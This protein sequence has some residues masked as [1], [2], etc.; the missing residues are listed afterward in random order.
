MKKPDHP[1][2]FLLKLEWILLAISCFLE[3]LP[4]PLT[5]EMQQFSLLPFLFIGVFG[6][7]GLFLPTK[8]NFRK[9]LY[10]IVEFALIGSAS[11]LIHGFHPFPFL[12]LLLMIRSCL[13]FELPGRL[14]VAAIVLVAFLVNFGIQVSQFDLP[15]QLESARFSRSGAEALN[16]TL[17][18][19]L[20]FGLVL[21][22]VLLLVNAL[23]S[24]RLSRQKLSDANLRLREY[25]RRIEDQ[26]A[27]QERN[28]IA[29]DIHDSLGHSLT[30]LNIQMEAVIELW[31]RDPQKARGFL[32]DAKHSGTTALQAVR[33]SV[34][35]LR[36]DPL[37]GH[38]LSS[39]LDSLA[40]E[41]EQTVGIAPACQ[42]ELTKK[43]SREVIH[44]IYC[45]VQEG[46][47]NICKH[48]KADFVRIKIWGTSEQ[49]HL[50]L[51][52]N[53]QGFDC[54]QNT[55]GFGLQGMR[56]RNLALGGDFKITSK[57]GRGCQILATFPVLE[58]AV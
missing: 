58:G 54:A 52:D 29:R 12:F 27:L 30:A 20:L 40:T 51:E 9:I 24:E 25:A 10:T 14:S 7:M 19:A 45:I 43:L 35:A 55:T 28:R 37:H 56:E 47:T 38:S 11:F 39:A 4:L 32:K 42:I 17:T 21:L 6:L 22:F 57:P 3:F 2:P 46:L 1:F 44:A 36:T 16:F 5:G 49:V 34:S 53:G 31:E 15:V 33:H 18:P 41:F 23:I 13:I 8:D 48:S 50:L 26:A